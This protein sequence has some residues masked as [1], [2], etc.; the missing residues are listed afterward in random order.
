MRRSTRS[1]H[2]YW[3]VGAV[4]AVVGVGAYFWSKR[5]QNEQ[6]APP[7]PAAP[8]ETP[9]AGPVHPIAPLP[10]EAPLPPLEASDAVLASTADSLLGGQAWRDLLQFDNVVRRWVI[11]IDALPRE[12]IVQRTSPA[13]AVA[14]ELAVEGDSA[15]GG[16][17][18]V[19][20]TAIEGDS[21][22]LMLSSANY[23]RYDAYVALAESID[24]ATLVS[25]Y[26]RLYP[27]FQQAYTELIRPDGYFNDRLI[28]VLDHVLATPDFPQAVRLSRPSVMYRYADPELEALSVARKA[29]LRMG[30]DNARRVKAVVGRVRTELLAASDP[31]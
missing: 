21:A 4:A 6:E 15:A 22:G 17:S 16:D 1:T 24:P 3:I 26:R 18:A 5:L 11:T 12:R 13:R 9:A 2:H 31:D 10:A 8:I 25:T 20:G 27:L 14:G 23:P 30:P 29:L 28:E 7:A 19:A